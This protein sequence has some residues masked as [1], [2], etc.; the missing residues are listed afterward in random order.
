MLKGGFSCHTDE[1]LW[2]AP[3]MRTHTRPPAC[4]GDKNLQGFTHVVILPRARMHRTIFDGGNLYYKTPPFK[5]ARLDLRCDALYHFTNVPG[6]DVVYMLPQ[7]SLLPPQTTGSP[8]RRW[9]VR[10]DP[11]WSRQ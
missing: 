6:P 2:L 10:D 1:R 9:L 11:F 5:G 3:G 8:G 4:H 7:A